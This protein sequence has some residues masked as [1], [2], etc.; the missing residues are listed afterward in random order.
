M[1]S[2]HALAMSELNQIRENNSAELE[3]RRAEVRRLSPAYAAVEADLM[4]GGNA[5][6]RSVLGG[7]RDFDK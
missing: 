6:L 4:K 5:L 3:R 7:S 1:Q 2:A